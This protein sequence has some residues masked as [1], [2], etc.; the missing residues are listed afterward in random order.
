[1]QGEGEI[2]QYI[3]GDVEFRGADDV[4]YRVIGGCLPHNHEQFEA[5]N[6]QTWRFRTWR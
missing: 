5:L 3:T 6:T 2:E 4:L 1:M